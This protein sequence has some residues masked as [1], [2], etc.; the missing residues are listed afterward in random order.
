MSATVQV[1]RAGRPPQ[2]PPPIPRRPPGQAVP[3]VASLTS[4]AAVL[5]AGGPVSAVVQGSGWFGYAVLVVAVVVGLGVLLHR[6]GTVVVAAGQ[7]LAMLVL[8]TVLFTGDG[9]LGF[10]PGPAVLQEFGRLVS[11]AG[12][13][14]DTGTAPVPAT[15]EILFLVTVAFGLLTVAVHLAAV[16]AEAPAAAGVPL[17]AVFA[18]PAALADNLLPWWSMVGAAAGFGLLLVTPTGI[19]RQLTGGGA[20]VAGAVALA[21]VLGAGATFVG[22]AGRFEGGSGAGASGG[23]IGLSP[24][25]SLRGQLD[26][27]TPV[28]LFRVRGLSRPTYLRALTL[29]QYV[30]DAGWQATRPAPGVPMPGPV[31]PQPNVPGDVVDLQIENVAFRDYWLPLY[32]EPIGVTGLPAEQWLYD[33]STGTGYTGRPRQEDSWEEHALLPVPTVAQLRAAQGNDGVGL[34]YLDT[35][36]VDPRVGEI[37]QQAVAGATNN[38][39]RAIAL[40]DYFTAPGSPFTYS[41]QTAPGA[42]DDALVEFLTVGRVGYCEQF[43]SA[44]AV[45]LR[46]VGVPARVAVGFTAG[47]D[48]GAYRSIS[49]SD[50]HAWV[51]AWFPGIGWTAFDPTPLTD[52]RSIDPPYVQEAR[53]QG[54][55]GQAGPTED[56]IAPEDVPGQEP[57]PPPTAPEQQ[58]PDAVSPAVPQSSGLPSLLWPVLVL[59]LVIAIG[60]VP[61]GLR[62]LDRRRRFAA[63]AAGGPD[64]AGAGWAELLAESTDRGVE[65]PP[66]DTVRATAR[67]LVREHR[68]E[69]D[70]QQALREVVGAVEGSWY[71]GTH[72]APGELDEPVRA[73]AAGIATGSP[74]RLRG[75][76][77]PPSVLHRL[78]RRGDSKQGSSRVPEPERETAAPRS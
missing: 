7:C 41:L 74:L 11:G 14:I 32:G 58:P 76:L 52:G 43:A 36:G 37:A 27:A 61:A 9:V 50:A 25:A 65:P 8:F 33:Q 75:R 12:Q 20:L 42:G 45:M 57:P 4:G 77:L 28:E 1:P 26:Q 21:L 13:Q 31:Q 16:A 55:N 40:Q 15:P 6:F 24:F 70:A 34:E 51:E 68:L 53:S 47:V 49:T 69:P 17:L 48:A 64:A 54:P 29:R 46:T 63:T 73:V 66:S 67:R 39:D 3:W 71:G 18:V 38:F 2:A 59:L 78:R 72:P 35:T 56:A 22:T 19:R 60:A 30:P 44:M 10:L 62:V 23:S 5:L